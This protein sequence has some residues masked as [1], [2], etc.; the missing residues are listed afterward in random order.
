MLPAS[1]TDLLLLPGGIYNHK[2]KVSNAHNLAKKPQ[3][4]HEKPT[5]DSTILPG[6]LAATPHIGLLRVQSRLAA[7][8]A[9]HSSVE[10]DLILGVPQPDLRIGAHA[11]RGRLGVP[12]EPVTR[13]EPARLRISPR[14]LVVPAGHLLLRGDAHLL[15]LLDRL[16]VAR[17]RAICEGT[18]PQGVPATVWA[19]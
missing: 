19:L 12:L 13:G 15:R 5:E 4:R 16:D 6:P 9:A 7:Q 11:A 18:G 2:T 10:P 8:P 17:H 3:P 1:P 14:L